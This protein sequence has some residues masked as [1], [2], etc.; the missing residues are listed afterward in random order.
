MKSLIKK[1]AKYWYEVL[2]EA[3]SGCE[4]HHVNGRIGVYKGCGVLM[5]PCSSARHK[6]IHN[7][8]G[9]RK[10]VKQEYEWIIK[11]VEVAYDKVFG[12]LGIGMNRC[13]N[14]PLRRKK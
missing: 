10:R 1:A 8:P 3:F 6:E 12:C 2:H 5:M 13:I 7:K 9:E 4:I 14:C 11:K